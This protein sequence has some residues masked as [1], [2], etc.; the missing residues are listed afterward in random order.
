MIQNKAEDK[1]C[2]IFIFY[3]EFI[4]I[5]I[6]MLILKGQDKVN[7]KIYIIDDVYK[8]LIII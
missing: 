1:N 2:L 7:T 6:D 3:N 5:L 4:R 8:Y